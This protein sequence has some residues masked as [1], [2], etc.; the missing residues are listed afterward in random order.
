M[1]SCH[2]NFWSTSALLPSGRTMSARRAKPLSG[3]TG[4]SLH[5]LAHATD[6]A[7]THAHLNSG[8]QLAPDRHSNVVWWTDGPRRRIAWEQLPAVNGRNS[9]DLTCAAQGVIVR[10]PASGLQ[11]VQQL[12][13][14]TGFTRLYAVLRTCQMFAI[15][16]YVELWLNL[17]QS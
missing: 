4:V 17:K 7:G 6:S 16:Q 3:N 11:Q 15:S 8:R 1:N 13:G 10:Y 14:Y 2:S 5:N 9:Q 12:N